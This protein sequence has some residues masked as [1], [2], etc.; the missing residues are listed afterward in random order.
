[1]DGPLFVRGA[2]GRGGA[3]REGA[4][5]GRG[6]WP[7]SRN[8]HWSTADGTSRSHTPN[9]DSERWERGGHRGGGRG[10]GAPRGAPRKFPNVTL[11]VNHATTQQ[12]HAA[13][14]IEHI[15]PDESYLQPEEEEEHYEEE[16]EAEEDE[17]YE[18]EVEQ[19]Q[20]TVAEET[21]TG[22]LIPEIH[23]PELETAEER[24][25]FYQELVKA[26]EIERKRA[27]AEGKMDDPLVPKR[28]ED[29]ISIVGTCMHMCPRFER[30]RRER[31]NNLFEWE[32][33]PGTK[34]VDHN[35]A[36]KMY[37]RAAGD[38]TLPSDLRPP[39][40]LKCTLDY[41]FH[42]LLPRGGFSA[43]FNFIRD[44]SRA[45]RND[46]T[47]QH[48]TG[49]LAIECHDRCARFHIL[50]LHFERDRPGF[51][52]PLEEQQLM[53]TL[54]SLKEFYQDQRGRY[55]SPTELEMRVY[56][57]L[58]HIRDQK[59]RH[60]DIPDYILSHP[61]FKLT[62]EFRLHVQRKSAPISKNSKLIVPEEAMQIFSQLAAVLNE[63]GSTVMVYLVACLLERLFGKDTID[64]IESIRG[65]LSISDIIDGV[66]VDN[67]RMQNGHVDEGHGAEATIEGDDGDVD[68][69]DAFLDGD[70]GYDGAEEEAEDH[71]VEKSQPAVA[72]N[73]NPPPT[74]WPSSTFSTKPSAP[75][76]ALAPTTGGAFG[77]LVSK[78]NVFGNGSVF[79]GPVFAP[80][81]PTPVSVF[82]NFGAPAPKPATNGIS[83]TSVATPLASTSNSTPPQ[84]QSVFA[85]SP[86]GGMSN[87]FPSKAT[88]PS[89]SP[90]STSLFGNPFAVPASTTT[91]TN[92]TSPAKSI[93]GG[94]N[95]TPFLI[96]TNNAP[97]TSSSLFTI[98]PSK[99]SPSLNPEAPE[100][101]PP[102]IIQP[103]TSPFAYQSIN[104]SAKSTLGP[105]PTIP[106][107]TPP[108]DTTLD[109]PKA[110]GANS[111]TQP[112]LP[113]STQQQTPPPSFFSKPN[114]PT[115]SS[116]S[117]AQTRPIAPPLLKIDTNTS[118][119]S[120][121]PSVA[122][123]KVPPPLARVQP[124]SLPSTPTM[125]LQPS[126]PLLDHLRNSLDPSS[127]SLSPS[128]S[129]EL[130]SPLVVGSPTASPMGSFSIKNFTPLSTP[131]ASRIFRPPSPPKSNGK[132]KAP[133]L[134]IYDIGEVEEMKKKALQFAQKSLI[135]RE[136]F[137][138]WLKKA[139][140][141]AAYL[142]ALKH[143]DEYRQK[144][145]RSNHARQQ[146]ALRTS[147][148]MDVVDKK[149]RISTNGGR[150]IASMSDGP[151]PMKKRARKRVSSEYRPPRT[152]EDLANRFKENHREHELRWAQGSFLQVIRNHI[153]VLNA[154]TLKMPWHIWL[155]MNPESDATAIWLER[156]FDVPDSGTWQNENV[157][158]IPI[159]S[160][161]G[162]ADGY[163]GVIVFECTPLGDVTDDLERK[164]RVLDDCAR[165]REI[166]KALPPKRH[167]IPSLLV[168]CW[169][170]GEQTPE[171]SDFFD[172]VKKL[173]AASTIRSSQVLNMTSAT[174]DLDTKLESALSS[175]TLDTEGLLVKPLTLKGAFRVFDRT[176]HQ[177]LSEWME[178][179]SVLGRFNWS[180]Y[181]QVVQVSITLLNNM[182]RAVRSM[183]ELEGL[184]D[185][186]PDF[187]AAQVTDS[188]SAYE[189]LFEWLSSLDSREDANQIAMDVQSHRNIGQDFPAQIFI[190]HLY[191]LTQARLERAH[192][193]FT[194]VTKP[195]LNTAIKSSLQSFKD[196]IEPH[197]MR[198]LQLYNFS[199]RRSPK[200]RAYSVATSDQGSP[201]TK[202]PR[203]LASVTS[204][205]N[206][207]FDIPSTPQVKMNGRRMET[208][209]PSPSN[210]SSATSSAPT[211]QDD[212]TH[213]TPNVTVA[214][215]RALTRDLKKK[216]GGS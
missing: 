85:P 98:T 91:T 125:V 166:I 200:R 204:S 197:Q 212:K 65:D 137:R 169:T 159:S 38:K 162:S 26:R 115:S 156:K 94:T 58:I 124:I 138:R 176:F 7:H 66:S 183:L 185:P 10:R 24:E 151:S 191:K 207:D 32:T 192:P 18:E 57:R 47:M 111:F 86:F 157:F 13:A 194:T 23:E 174:K 97:T 9:S 196:E 28:L 146:L 29:A 173:T 56:H 184:A 54:Q 114:P 214:M 33:I 35:R 121:S 105:K 3:T 198:L 172:M 180:L 50:A 60:E 63:Q 53:N 135:M 155:A 208:Q 39:L 149:R 75:T 103:S 112:S 87:N 160:A 150:A 59:E 4:R 120:S 126:N 14:D 79:G 182:E 101:V 148:N 71:E 84:P 118:S 62:T 177:F 89:S 167:F 133:D 8:K 136:C 99:P 16:Q 108:P 55:D 127:S 46:F 83:S 11:R 216:Y 161:S 170:E 144:I 92:G 189:D 178:N 202:R 140:D 171:E 213:N 113:G 43:T 77:N 100:F 129:Q 179:C 88:E 209:T 67:P 210:S 44:R 2:R 187:N 74:G 205:V 168:I 143:G 52:L 164:Y 141:R 49:P 6:T 90:A 1:M 153:Q 110:N 41:L 51:S 215:L 190:E 48:I 211:E 104:D 22:R 188:E 107:F 25:K 80:S 193:Q 76:P 36:V 64:D 206:G 73:I 82:G 19:V 145:H 186:L 134:S 119:G 147:K 152:D 61:V 123:P 122:S 165:L 195:V 93:F 181:G 116:A 27:I 21:E 42:D 130:L 154:S 158:S 78:P 12:H 37:E 81:N 131:Q 199:V 142:E 30:Y 117:P 34:R 17:I 72:G 20:E 5:G 95:G 201:E 132:G 68:D 128:G 102:Q 175:L 139:M 96:S 31:E 106:F 70:D 15:Q 109:A 163:P 69:E 40:I 45:V 203:L